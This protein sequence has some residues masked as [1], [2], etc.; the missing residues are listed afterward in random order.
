M[1]KDYYKILDI[2]EFSTQDEIK[3]AYH[4]LARKWHPDVAGNTDEIISKF[5]EINEAY[6][7][8]SNKVKKEDYDRARKFYNYSSSNKNN[9]KADSYTTQ[10]QNNKKEKNKFKETEKSASFSFKWSDFVSKYYSQNEKKNAP[11]RGDDINTDIEITISEAINGTTKIINML[12]T[13]ICPYCKGRKFVN[14]TTCSHCHGNGQTSK[15]KK[16]SVKIPS[17]I[18]NNSKIRLA[19]EGENGTNGGVSGDLYITVHILEPQN[20]TTQGYDILKNIEISPSQAVLGTEVKIETIRGKVSV[21][22][23]PNTK[24][25][26]KIRLKNCGLENNSKFGDMILTVTIQIPEKL[27]DEEIELYKMLQ[28]IYSKKTF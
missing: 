16:F 4:K 1:T 17:G 20:Y 12:Q 19:G 9:N 22:I 27:S 15:Y 28:E 5:K 14:G 6:Q 18:K 13:Q 26:Q 8:L 25:G 10:P 23:S 24:N 3:A 7:I 11:K 2:P 21:K